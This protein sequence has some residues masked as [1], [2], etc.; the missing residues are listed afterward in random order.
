[1]KHLKWQI[2]IFFL[3][4]IFGPKLLAELGF[5]GTWQLVIFYAIILSILILINF[6]K[7]L[8]V[9]FDQK[10]LSLAFRMFLAMLLVVTIIGVVVWLKTGRIGW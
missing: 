4:F 3:I 7:S 10:I 9:I 2:V 6:A 5:Y 1:M 8:K